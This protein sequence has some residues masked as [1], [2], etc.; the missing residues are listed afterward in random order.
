MK[1]ETKK[2]IWLIGVFVFLIGFWMYVDSEELWCAVL[3][4]MPAI[5]VA[6]SIGGLV[7]SIGMIIYHEC[8]GETR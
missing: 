2:W 1:Q 3:S 5:L 6:G 4:L 8:T 7:G